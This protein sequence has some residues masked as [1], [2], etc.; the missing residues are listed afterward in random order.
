MTQ[1]DLACTEQTVTDSPNWL[2]FSIPG[3]GHFIL[4][5]I[6]LE[7]ES[8]GTSCSG[9]GDILEIC[10]AGHAMKSWLMWYSWGYINGAPTSPLVACAAQKHFWIQ[11]S[12]CS[13]PVEHAQQYAKVRWVPRVPLNRT[14]SSA[15][16]SHAQHKMLQYNTLPY[17]TKCSRQNVWTQTERPHNAPILTMQH[18]NS[19]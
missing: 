18:N 6:I 13:G 4:C 3:Y 16:S 11:T 8:R 15:L 12:A 9:V 2:N 17:K 1:I 14:S 7:D 5:P 10:S 19:Y